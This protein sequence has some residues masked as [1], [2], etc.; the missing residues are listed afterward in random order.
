MIQSIQPN[1]V[2]EKERES[3]LKT[4]IRLRLPSSHVATTELDTYD[5]LFPLLLEL[6]GLDVVS[7]LAKGGLEGFENVVDILSVIVDGGDTHMTLRTD[8][9]RHEMAKPC[10]TEKTQG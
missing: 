2:R 10:L 6:L 4:L 3:I 9:K 7:S 8:K 5:L 1:G